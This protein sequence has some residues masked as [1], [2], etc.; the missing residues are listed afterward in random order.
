MKYEDV[1]KIVKGRPYI[2]ERNARQLY[3]FIIENKIE[4]VVEL[5]I[6]HG[7]ASCY[8]AAA[9]H[10]LG[11]GKLV[12]VDLVEAKDIFKPTIEEQL[13]ECGLTSYVDVVREQSGYNWFLHNEISAQTVDNNCKTKYDLCIIDGPKNWT[14]DGAAFFMVDK[15]LNQRGWVIFDDYG[16]T[17][18]KEIKAGNTETDG[19]SHRNLSDQELHSP[20][21][22]EV[23][24]LLVMQHENYG[25]FIVHGEGDWAWAQK[26]KQE[27]K[28][29]TFKYGVTYKDFTSR[30]FR[31]INKVFKFR[32]VE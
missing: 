11:K 30:I 25:N 20:Q 32:K 18:D 14:I 12:S 6:A 7:T 17:Y 23:F 22:K 29:I 31:V 3:N 27:N 8:I 2:T 28:N 13:S 9:L 5:G 21:I 1:H 10:E 26:V 15:L 4:N 19:I 16:W 24:H